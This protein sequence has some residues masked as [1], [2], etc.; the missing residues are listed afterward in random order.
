MGGCVL[1]AMGIGVLAATALPVVPFCIGV[2][3]ALVVG[4]VAGLLLLPSPIAVLM[5]AI[6]LFAAVQVGYG[7]GLGLWALTGYRRLARK[8]EFGSA[9]AEKHAPHPR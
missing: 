3:V 7:V 6:I 9:P 1:L 4:L 2:V 8:R 5:G